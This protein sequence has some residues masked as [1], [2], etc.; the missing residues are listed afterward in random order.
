MLR[1]LEMIWMHK[2]V[3]EELNQWAQN[4]LIAHLGIHFIEVT[5]D[6]LH[7]AMPIDVR[8]MQPFHVLHGGA[9]CALI[10]TTANAAANFCVD[11]D[12]AHCVGLEINVNHI[13]TVRSGK[14]VAIAKP[15][16][17]GRTTQVWGVQVH[18]EQRQLTAVGRLTVAI[19]N[20]VSE[21]KELAENQ[22][23]H[24]SRY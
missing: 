17:L 12:K 10:E 8:T 15:F 4:S 18:N 9:S 14:V 24:G 5:D 23:A 7:A 19:L 2:P 11:P 21:K 16:H 3:L 13:K 1:Y 6:A 22:R 20:L